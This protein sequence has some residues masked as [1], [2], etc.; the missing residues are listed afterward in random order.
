MPFAYCFW[1]SK[2]WFTKNC[3][4]DGSTT[5]SSEHSATMLNVC[6]SKGMT[7]HCSCKRLCGGGLCNISERKQH[8]PRE[9][10]DLVLATFPMLLYRSSTAWA[11]MSLLFPRPLN[12]YKEVKQSAT[13]TTSF[14]LTRTGILS[15]RFC[16]ILTC[17]YFRYLHSLWLQMRISVW[18]AW[19]MAKSLWNCPCEHL[20]L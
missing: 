15:W 11:L 3:K 14:T 4:A 13:K 12:S 9:M 19:D 17:N 8:R 2:S 1:K 20:Q 5:Y 7:E 18:N 10:I 16:L 6:T